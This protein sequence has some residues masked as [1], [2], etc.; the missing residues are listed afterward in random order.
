MRLGGKKLRV[1]FVAL[2]LALLYLI[3]SRLFPRAT[4]LPTNPRIL[5]YSVLLALLAECVRAAR[6]A[7][8]YWGG[9]DARRYMQAL[10]ARFA[11]NLAALITPSVAGGE[12]V[13]GLVIHGRVETKAARAITAAAVDSGADMIGNYTLAL[14]ALAL[15][16]APAAP[17]PEIV[18]AAPAAAWLLV[19]ALLPLRTHKRILERIADKLD[20]MRLRLLSSISSLLREAAHY[21]TEGK[22]LAGALLLTLVAWLLQVSSYAVFAEPCYAKAL[23]C[24]TETVLMGVIPVPGGIGP[25]EA[26]LATRC[27]GIVSWRILYTVAAVAPGALLVVK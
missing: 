9:L 4:M 1:A 8:L 18:A 17:L 5:A 26:L 16:S 6:L 21:E 23:G 13:R 25:G 12:V 20:A 3:L 27:A 7:L 22:M 10:R 14:L 11:G 2:Y 15:G 19:Y 24:V